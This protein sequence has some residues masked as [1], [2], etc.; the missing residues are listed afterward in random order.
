MPQPVSADYLL[1]GSVYALEQCGLLLRDANILYRSGSY[2][3]VIVLAAFGRE[4]LGHSATLL[5]W[6][7]EALGGK[8]FT[9]TDIQKRQDHETKQKAGML[10]S[11][12]KGSRRVGELLPILSR[13]VPQ[14]AEWKAAHEEIEQLRAIQDRRTSKDRHQKRVSALYVEPTS[15]H[16]WNRPAITSAISAHDFLQHA[17]NDYAGRYQQ[18]YLTSFGAELLPSIDPELFAALKRWSDRPE[19]WPPEWPAMPDAECST[20]QPGRDA[21]IGKGG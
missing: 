4:E 8:S 18:R 2:A 11:V 19:L 1:K 7:R 3:S 5:Q 21:I 17:V 9:L 15:P 10:S 14:S 16:Q 6:W 20:A 12:M 13:T